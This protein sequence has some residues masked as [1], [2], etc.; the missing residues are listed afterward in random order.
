MKD[1]WTIA[2]VIFERESNVRLKEESSWVTGRF[3]KPKAKV[4]WKITPDFTLRSLT[5][6]HA[7][8]LLLLAAVALRGARRGCR[9]GPCTRRI[10][11]VRT[12]RLFRGTFMKTIRKAG[13]LECYPGPMKIFAAML[14]RGVQAQRGKNRINHGRDFAPASLKSAAARPPR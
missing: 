10:T 1:P 9:I 6:I 12:C 4:L 3:Q 14:G 8:H 2:D 11:F 7:P 5:R 13:R